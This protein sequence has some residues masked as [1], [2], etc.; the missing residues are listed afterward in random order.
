M[1]GIYKRIKVCLICICAPLSVHNINNKFAV[2]NTMYY[3]I[4]G[5][6]SLAEKPGQSLFKS[7]KF[8]KIVGHTCAGTDHAMTKFNRLRLSFFE[9]RKPILRCTAWI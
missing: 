9:K 2:T 1:V 4:S 8:S 6:T 5:V 7:S 3:I